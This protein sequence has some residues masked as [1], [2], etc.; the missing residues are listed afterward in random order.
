[1]SSMPEFGE[2]YLQEPIEGKLRVVGSPKTVQFCVVCGDRSSGHH[3]GVLTCE[4]C[5]AFFRRWR[6]PDVVHKLRCINQYQNCPI[7]I[8][9]RS[10]C[11]F[12]RYKKCIDQGMQSE[13]SP[14]GFQKVEVASEGMDPIFAAAMAEKMA[15]VVKNHATTCPFTVSKTRKLVQTFYN[16]GITSD[17]ELI[18]RIEAWQSYSKEMERDIHPLAKFIQGLRDPFGPADRAALLKKHIFSIHLLRCTRGFVSRGLMLPDGRLLNQEV[19]GILYGRQLSMDMEEFS[20]KVIDSGMTDEDIGMMI[21]FIYYQPLNPADQEEM[22]LNNT[23]DLERIQ[24]EYQQM[25]LDY[26]PLQ[27]EK[28]QQMQY[29]MMDLNVLSAKH[30]EVQQFLRTHHEYFKNQEIF[31]EVFIST[32][33]NLRDRTPEE[34]EN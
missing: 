26:Y 22:Q 5:K 15:R 1:M 16:T 20:R 24:L 2:F 10:K 18:R 34:Q 31:T 13:C 29:L 19:L 27:Q 12:C 8:I 3:Y 23:I 17:D 4:G 32:Y 6:K 25:F 9:T 11:Q 33:S 21:T 7:T 30:S 28:L 14:R